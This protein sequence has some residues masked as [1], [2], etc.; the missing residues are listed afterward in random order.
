MGKFVQ[1]PA[2]WVFFAALLAVLGAT[3]AVALAAGIGFGMLYR[4]PVPAGIPGLSKKMLQGA[5]IVMG[6]GLNLQTLVSVGVSSVQVTLFTVA[7][8]VLLGMVLGRWFGM[9]RDLTV[10]VSSGT[11]ICGGSA[12]A[13]MS[14]VVG[15]SQ[16]TM[17]M[18]MAIVFSLNGLALF[19]FPPFGEWMGLSQE[20]FGFWAALAIH[21]T[22]S[23]VGAAATYGAVALAVGTTVKLTR[24][25]WI[26]PLA[27]VGARLS[28]SQ[29]RPPFQWFLVGFVAASAIRTACAGFEGMEGVWEGLRTFGAWLMV[30][31]LFLIGSTLRWGELKRIGP[32]SLAMAVLLWVIVSLAS[33]WLVVKGWI[34]VIRST[35]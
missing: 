32:K 17:A 11:A 26:F 28:G 21:D 5:V 24:A 27:F 12:I 9:K 35:T 1:H 31:T 13:A 4:A 16:A 30:A 18:A 14:P 19:I 22:S 7:G 25:L 23:V 34:P 6:F 3:P 29:K 10:L 15:A 20:Q 8:T 2:F 33:L